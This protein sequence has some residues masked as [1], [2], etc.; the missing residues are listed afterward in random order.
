MNSSI[1]TQGF[2]FSLFLFS[3]FV[4][5][6]VQFE[7]VEADGLDGGKKLSLLRVHGRAARE[8]LQREGR[9]QRTRHAARGL[10]EDLLEALE[11]ESSRPLIL[12]E[13]TKVGQ[14]QGAHEVSMHVA[15]YPAQA[16]WKRE[17]TDQVHAHS[18]HFKAV[19]TRRLPLARFDE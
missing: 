4:S 16:G 12:A 9:E 7:L 1:C 3:N 2:V 19:E 11:E 8:Y 5:E 17:A 14:A 10:H 15:A 18:F 13:K 6:L